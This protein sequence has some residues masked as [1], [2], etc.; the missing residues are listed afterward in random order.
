MDIRKWL[1]ET[2]HPV[3]LE[4]PVVE[5]LLLPRQPD[6]V[7]DA[8]RRRK[9]SLTDSSLLKAP[10]PQPQCKGVPTIERDSRHVRGVADRADSNTSHSTRSELASNSNTGQRYARRPRNKKRPDGHGTETKKGNNPRPT[11]RSESRKPKRRS[12]RKKEVEKTHGGIRQELRA[13]NISKDRLTLKPLE[14]MGIFSKGKAST[15]AKGRGLPDLVFSEMRFLRTDYVGDEHSAQATDGKKKRKKDHAQAKEEDISAFF[16]SIRPALANVAANQ[17]A[18]GARP[19]VI[20]PAAKTDRRELVREEP[21]VLDAAVRTASPEDRVSYL[22]SASRR[23]RRESTSYVSWSESFR[24][25]STTPG[26]RERTPAVHGERLGPSY[27]GRKERR[28][29]HASLRRLGTSSI[30]RE[31]IVAVTEQARGSLVAPLHSGFSRL[32]SLPRRSSPP[33]RSISVDQ[34]VT[35]RTTEDGPLLSSIWPVLRSVGNRDSQEHPVIGDSRSVRS[36]ATSYASESA[37]LTQKQMSE[38]AATTFVNRQSPQESSSLG[39]I[40]QYCNNS[41]Y[42]ER[43]RTAP[44]RS[45]N[46]GMRFSPDLRD[47]ARQSRQRA[48]GRTTQLATIALLAPDMQSRQ[49]GNFSGPGLYAQ[50]EQRQHLAVP[51]H[52]EEEHGLQLAYSGGQGPASEVRFSAQG[53][54]ESVSEEPVSYGTMEE[55]DGEDDEVAGLVYAAGDVEAVHG[56]RIT[57][58][59]FWRPNKLY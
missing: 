16:T 5:P 41:S 7:P 17:L 40:L 19:M 21:T 34:V 56:T 59:G 18:N 43:P 57:S 42:A 47:A 32:R 58:S 14:K 51:F 11:L 1:A 27:R 45:H 20:A 2:E 53:D 28:Q 12:R 15:T 6:S 9:R 8:R 46:V 52:V 33:S 31:P 30:V 13:N 36:I 24:A 54:V 48:H 10:S 25:P 39:G 44:R 38:K 4:R 22:W 23:P 50:Q 29:R 35:R 49:V 26:H 55:L 37:V 3:P